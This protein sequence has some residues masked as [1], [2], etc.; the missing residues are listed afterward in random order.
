MNHDLSNVS[1][2]FESRIRIQMIASL[3][4][5]DLT[6]N[7]LK[8]ICKCTDGNMTTHTKKLIDENFISIKK[9]FVKNKPQTTYHLTTL[10]RKSFIEYVEIL[11]ELVKNN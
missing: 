11:N 5:S 3:S 2:V 10:G 1:K 7:Q 4:I 9:E 6:Y 8:E